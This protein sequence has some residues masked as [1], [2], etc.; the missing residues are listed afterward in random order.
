MNLCRIIL[1]VTLFVLIES[2]SAVEPDVA[3]ND[4]KARKHL[5]SIINNIKPVAN[6]GTDNNAPWIQCQ[7]ALKSLNKFKLFSTVNMVIEAKGRKT[8]LLIN[9]P[10]G[11]P[12]AY[13]SD[14]TFNAL[15]DIAPV[16]W[17]NYSGVSI[18]ISYGIKSGVKPSNRLS[19]WFRTPINNKGKT[20]VRY[21][22]K[23]VIEVL[24][25]KPDEELKYNKQTGVFFIDRQ[26]PSK[27]EVV[28]NTP[29]EAK[30][31]GSP[32]NR[33]SFLNKF[34]EGISISGITMG[35]TPISKSIL[36]FRCKNP[37]SIKNKDIAPEFQKI[38][39]KEAAKKFR[40]VYLETYKLPPKQQELSLYLF[41]QFTKEKIEI[42]TVSIQK[43]STL[44][45]NREST[46]LEKNNSLSIIEK[47]LNHF[48]I[49]K[50]L[51]NTT[52][53]DYTLELYYHRETKYLELQRMLGPKLHFQLQSALVS[54]VTSG[55]SV[56]INRSNSI[57]MI[58]R[59]GLSSKLFSS[60]ENFFKLNKDDDQIA[61]WSAIKIRL[62]HFDKSDV[63]RVRAEMINP[64]VLPTLRIDCLESLLLINELN[65]KDRKAILDILLLC[66]K[67]YY[68][69]VAASLLSSEI[70]ISIVKKEIL[71]N[72]KHPLHSVV[73]KLMKKL[74][75]RLHM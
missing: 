39:T 10:D 53:K 34:G 25:L 45:F 32:I 24:L 48:S 12:V 8:A 16:K 2:V 9:T 14:S 15:S 19:L 22:L 64:T 43:L 62:R 40:F 31:T 65:T 20:S 37:F 1:I 21:N 6:D 73:L 44:L 5:I 72:S 66:K 57:R 27:A 18:N 74:N 67:N 70:G 71:N 3:F 59:W 52:K 33:I 61:L 47:K 4:S 35:K 17:N 11:Y 29:Y 23:E 38:S 55:T 63:E 28:L 54:T 69:R 26:S 75:L 30:R 58:G 60:L 7:V 46:Q 42:D 49:I 50:A 68:E 56:S 36:G 41:K 13:L 51:Y